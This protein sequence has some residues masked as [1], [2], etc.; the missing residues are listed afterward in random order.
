M[1]VARCLF[2]P[3]YLLLID[4]CLLLILQGTGKFTFTLLVKKS[5]FFSLVVLN[6]C[7]H[8]C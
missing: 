1:L 2:G 4:L 3:R 8:L 6:V 5:F 7:F